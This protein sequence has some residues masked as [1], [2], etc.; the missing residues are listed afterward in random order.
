MSLTP[1]AGGQ[2]V[3]VFDNFGLSDRAKV[4]RSGR[5]E[6]ALITS[7]ALEI[8]QRLLE[9]GLLKTYENKS[10]EFSPQNHYYFGDV[11][12]MDRQYL[13]DAIL[14]IPRP[15]PLRS[16]FAQGTS[17]TLCRRRSRTS[18]MRLTKRS[19]VPTGYGLL[20]SRSKGSAWEA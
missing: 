16:Q 1:P 7:Q 11:V 12:V 9:A 5:C 2:I 15:D 8:A 20:L 4:R 6:A 3:P 13:L 10:D 18:R 19:A 14:D 17:W